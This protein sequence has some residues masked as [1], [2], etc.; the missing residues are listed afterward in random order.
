MVQW[1]S[2][3]IVGS[4]VGIDERRMEDNINIVFEKKIS[5]D[6][7]RMELTQVHVQ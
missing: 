5:K 6:V 4:L 7:V 1:V 3:W 2:G